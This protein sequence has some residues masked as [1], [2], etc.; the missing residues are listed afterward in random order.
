MFGILL[1]VVYIL[2]KNKLL[3]FIFKKFMF[4]LTTTNTDLE[5]KWIQQVFELSPL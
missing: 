4:K 2:K 3:I 1:L 5:K